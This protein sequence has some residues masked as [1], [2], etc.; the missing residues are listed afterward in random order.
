MKKERTVNFP[1]KF[2][3]LMII[4]QNL[5]TIKQICAKIVVQYP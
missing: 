2:R 3:E 4:L 5:E 1:D